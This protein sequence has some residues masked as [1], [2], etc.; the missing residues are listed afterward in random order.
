MLNYATLNWSPVLHFKYSAMGSAFAWLM[1]VDTCCCLPSHIAASEQQTQLQGKAIRTALVTSL[2]SS[3]SHAI[4]LHISTLWW[5][6]NVFLFPSVCFSTVLSFF[7]LLH[8]SVVL[9][10]VC[11]PH[12]SLGTLE[13]LVFLWRSKQLDSSVIW[14]HHDVFSFKFSFCRYFSFTIFVQIPHPFVHVYFA[15]IW[16]GISNV[17]PI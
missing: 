16:W 8:E 9:S 7:Y 10:S 17:F 6:C 14:P 11:C 1:L 15:F 5:W 13:C 3:N 4:I 12:F 2:V